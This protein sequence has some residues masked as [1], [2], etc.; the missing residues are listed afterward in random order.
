MTARPGDPDP[1]RTDQ[2]VDVEQAVEAGRAAQQAQDAQE[3]AEAAGA[4]AAA[5]ITMPPERTDT[6]GDRR[7][8][9]QVINRFGV[10]GMPVNRGH[11]FYVGFMGATGVLTAYW[12]LGMLGQ[13]S[14]V[15]TLLIVAL[16]LALG[17]EPVVASLER[18]G[19]ARGAAVAVVFVGVIALFI[20]FVSAVAP[21]LV[22]QGTELTKAAPDL[23]N[24]FTNSALI[25]SLDQ[26]Y[27][28]I[29]SVTAQVQQRLANGQTVVQLFGGVFG[30]GAA[31]VSGAFSAFTVLVLT[32]YFTASLR[33]MTETAYRLVPASRRPRVQLLADEI[34]R[35]IGGYIAG[36]VAVASINGVF[37]FIGLTVLKLPY[38]AVL[39]ITVALFGLIPLVGASLGAVIVV[40]VGL[41]HS[42]QYAVIILIYYVI[43][44]QVENYAIAP[45][46]MARTVSVP[47]AVAVVAAL[48]GGALL[49]VVGALIAIP[50]AAGVLLIVQEVFVPRQAEH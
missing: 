13:L 38:A 45:R 43:Y 4:A 3:A 46:I 37:T 25:R 23:V 7:D 47:G 30:A 36:Q 8:D 18:Q 6:S 27:G 35:R 1:T 34:M 29:S 5:A 24:S 32:L 10:P 28:L 2:P 22:T 15:L 14:S 50:V 41:F 16:F 20:G 19:M 26:K 31:V 49:G 17:L 9:D 42:W 33:S 44:Q 40:L 11:P 12:L 21:T 48:A 39:A